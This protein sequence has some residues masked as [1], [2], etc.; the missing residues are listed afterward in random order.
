MHVELIIAGAGG[1]TG[2]GS[3]GRAAR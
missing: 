2:E 1:Q 3:G